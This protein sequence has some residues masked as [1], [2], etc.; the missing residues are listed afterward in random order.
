MEVTLRQIKELC[1]KQGKCYNC[2][3]L[4]DKCLIVKDVPESWDVEAIKKV[5]NKQ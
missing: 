2:P 4:S 1:E 5:L 3:L